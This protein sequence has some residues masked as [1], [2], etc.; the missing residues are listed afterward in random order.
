[1]AT[2]APASVVMGRPRPRRSGS[3]NGLSGRKAAFHTVGNDSM[4][5]PATSL[6]D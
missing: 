5:K 6:G 4:A 2:L 1:M 3:L